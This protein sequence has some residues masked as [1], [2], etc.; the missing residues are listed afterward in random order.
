MRYLIKIIVTAI[1]ITGISEASK[2]LTT[3]G[4]ILASLPLTS[5][6]AIVWLYLDTKNIQKITELSYS[7][8]WVVIP[9]LSFFIALP[10]L[11][12]SGLNFWLS[13]VLSCVITAIIYFVYLFI[14]KKLGVQI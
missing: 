4:A 5:L 14:I 9:S 11:L 7:I 2:R 13:L 12:K 3:L 10:L 6:L 8:F 1:V